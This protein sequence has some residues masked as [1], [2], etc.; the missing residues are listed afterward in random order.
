MEPEQE[1]KLPGK[2][3]PSDGFAGLRASA[4]PAGLA[5]SSLTNAA[6]WQRPPSLF[7]ELALDERHQRPQRLVRLGAF[8]L[9]LDLVAH[10]GG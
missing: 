1:K 5:A 8:S 7:P 2:A 9:H 4:P 6:R 10:G 3:G